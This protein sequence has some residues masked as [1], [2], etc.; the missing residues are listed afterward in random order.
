MY[1]NSNRN[2]AKIGLIHP[3]KYKYSWEWMNTNIL[4]IIGHLVYTLST[5]KHRYYG[6]SISK[7]WP[8]A[9]MPKLAEQRRALSTAVA[10][11]EDWQ[12][13]L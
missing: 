7:S 12:Q 11:G 1:F 2:A 13:T 6:R 8:Y 4:G 5:P 10:M 3:Y 9:V